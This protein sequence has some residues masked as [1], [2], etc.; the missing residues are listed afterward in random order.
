MPA[1]VVTVEA[2]YRRR[3]DIAAEECCRAYVAVEEYHMTGGRC[4]VRE[5]EQRECDSAGVR[6]VIEVR[7]G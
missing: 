1:E 4:S 5:T 6:S 2:K 3:E 7:G